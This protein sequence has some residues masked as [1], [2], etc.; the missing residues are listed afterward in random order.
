MKYLHPFLL[1]ALLVSSACTYTEPGNHHVD[2]HGTV[3]IP[4][5]AATMTLVDDDGTEREVTDPRLFGPVYVGAYASVVTDLFDFPHPEVGPV[6]SSGTPGD[7]YPYGGNTLG[8]F[9][10]GCYQQLVC[11]TITGRYS[12]Y[13]D[14][15]DFFDTVVNRP[16]T[17]EF[18]DPVTGAS[19]YQEQ[20]YEYRYFTSDEEV[21]F[22]DD[23]HL[24]FK[25]SADGEFYEA[26]V[27]VPHTLFIEG[28]TVWGW[29]DMPSREFKF[30]TCDETGGELL[31][32]YSEQYEVGASYT[33]LLN[34]PG[35]YIDQGDW[36]GED[37]PV[38]T[39][40]EDD[41]VLTLGYYYAG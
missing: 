19:Q 39:T 32:Y 8:R 18:G 28:L 1:G 7:A 29:V 21:E 15:I 9:E 2:L 31:Y 24:D 6:L 34:F 4:V 16:I 26:E 12:S 17:D 41:F 14:V 3:R 11:Q 5:A 22:I 13:D 10:W 20:C 25:L 40:A 30:S 33:D 35:T 27:T 23:G 38:L 36:V 37:P